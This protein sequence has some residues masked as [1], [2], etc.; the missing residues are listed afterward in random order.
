MGFSHPKIQRCERLL[1]SCF[2]TSTRSRT[3][4]SCRYAFATMA[5]NEQAVNTA[6]KAV[7]T[8]ARLSWNTASKRN[9]VPNAGQG[10]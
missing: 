4:L 1:S 2:A 5:H 7:Y 9:A 8:T 6:T 3:S 10:R